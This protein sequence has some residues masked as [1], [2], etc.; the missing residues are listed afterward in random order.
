MYIDKLDAI[1]NKYSNKCHRII[2][3]KHVD[4]NPSIY[5]DF[6]KKNNNQEIR[7]YKVGDHV[8]MQK[9]KNIFAKD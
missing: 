2:K 6:N 4:V 9:Y 3:I 1:V 7:I 5:T 8:R